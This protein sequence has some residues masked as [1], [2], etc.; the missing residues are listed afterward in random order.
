M[1]IDVAI[2]GSGRWGKNHVKT[3]H[4][5][6]RYL[7]IDDIYVCDIDA[8]K[9]IQWEEKSFKC[10][11]SIDEL[12]VDHKPS[13]AVVATPPETHF[14]ITQILLKQGISV[15]V[16]KPIAANLSDA[17]LLIQQAE[18]SNCVLSVGVLLRF[19]SGIKY[20]WQMLEDDKIGDVKSIYFER[21]SSRSPTNSA[22][23]I[24]AMGIH[25]IDTI[26]NLNNENE[27][28]LI[29]LL[30]AE[31]SNS[32]VTKCE[33]LLDYGLEFKAK[34]SI[35][36]GFENESRIVHIIGSNGAISIDF[37]E[38][39]GVTTIIDNVIHKPISALDKYPL[40][41]ELNHMAKNCSGSSLAKIFPG[42]TG[43]ING[44]KWSTLAKK[45]LS[46]YLAN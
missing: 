14:D 4:Q 41:L 20:A 7:E 43:I 16:E 30:S 15:L 25:A 26:L 24:D 32:Q 27:P 45:E 38:P 5:N 18:E 31:S 44:L 33:F 42:K 34:F 17:E 11:T 35:G 8:R 2:I 39:F 29:S 10:F 46:K 13:F 37:S 12:L 40:E 22:D 6:S 19:H 1:G 36:W 3:I 23:L 21:H 9:L 28:N